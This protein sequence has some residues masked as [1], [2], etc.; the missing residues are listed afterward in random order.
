MTVQPVALPELQAFLPER[1]TLIEYLVTGPETVVW[2]IDRE[3]VTTLWKVEDRATYEVAQAFYARLA[4][5]GPAAAAGGA[6]TGDGDPSVSVLLGPF[7]LTGG[8]FLSS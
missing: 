4:G 7:V 8:D 5:A 2:V 6:A 1:T 3:R